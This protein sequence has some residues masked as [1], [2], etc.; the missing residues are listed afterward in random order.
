MARLQAAT[1]S[2]QVTKKRKRRPPGANDGNVAS[3]SEESITKLPSGGTTSV[4]TKI[5]DGGMKARRTTQVNEGR[6]PLLS[7][8]SSSS[9][10]ITSDIPWP[11]HFKGLAQTHRAL[12]LVFTFCCTRKHLAT[13][14]DNIRTA[15]ETHIKRELKVEDVAQIKA[16]VPRAINFTYVDEAMLQTHVLGEQDGIKNRRA[17]DFRSLEEPVDAERGA[18]RSSRELLLFEF[19]DGDLKR[20]VQ[21]SKTGEPTKPTRKLREEDLKM[22]VYSQKQMTN[23]I[24]KR[25]T[26]FTS[27]IN[28]FLNQ[29]AADQVDPVERI[30][31]DQSLY[32]PAPTESRS[33]TPGPSG[34]TITNLPP[35]I[36]SERKTIAEIVAEIKATEWY[37]GQIVPDGHRVFDPQPPIYGE[38]SFPLSQS[39]VNALYNT[40]NIT[41]LYSH[42]AE[43]INNLHEGHHVIISTST[44]SGKSLI[45]QI[46]VLHELERDKNTRA[47]YIFPTKALA[48]D[49]RRSL[50]ELLG[51]MKGLEDIVVETYDGDT[52]MSDRNLI[53]DE[54]RIIFT[55]PDMLHITILPQEEAWRT[56][57]RNLKYVVVDGRLLVSLDQQHGR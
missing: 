57:L 51:Y 44:S 19:I 20:Q 18:V 28:A 31:Q 26:K 5:H 17:K 6:P 30:Q 23:L 40:R 8:K 14:F 4:P 45:Y 37:T 50:K 34:R 43:A 32:I 33:T 3:P 22:P 1:V 9:S 46:P 38:L 24:S 55:N 15:V 53:R 39:L 7:R 49:Q 12:N 42:Q 47:M 16:L 41:K 56:F 48:Q 27:A 35:T 25:N 21:H 11:E 13:T 36:P 2:N 10:V 29:C 54:G 52:Q